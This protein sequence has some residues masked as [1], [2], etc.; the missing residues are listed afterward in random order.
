[1]TL[2]QQ[3]SLATGILVISL[4][5]GTLVLSIVSGRSYYQDQL[6]ASAYDAATALALS[7]TQAETAAERE[8]QI[9]V[10][11][12]RG[13]YSDI[14]FQSTSGTV[15]QRSSDQALEAPAPTWFMG[16]VAFD[17]IPASADVTDGWRR[18]GTLQ[19][20]SHPD[21]AYR[22]M[23]DAALG[24]AVWFGSVLLMAIVVL[25][26]LIDWL[27]R[28]I[29]RVEQQALGICERE[30]IVQHDIPNVRE[31]R[32]MVLAMNRMVE[33]VHAMFTEHADATD[34][35]QQESFHDPITGLLNR[36]GFDQKVAHILESEQ[37][38][39]G[40]LLILQLVEFGTYNH[41]HGRRKGDEFL[42]AVS[43]GL[44]EWRG[45]NLDIVLGRHSGADFSVYAPCTDSE[46]AEHVMSELYGHLG[47]RVLSPNSHQYFHIGGTY[48]VGETQELAA[49][50]SEAD[51]ALRQIQRNRISGFKLY[52]PSSSKEPPRTAQEWKQ[53]LEDCLEK[54]SLE[55]RFMPYRDAESKQVIQY[56]LHSRFKLGEEL[57]NA[58]RF[59]PMVEHHG[60]G[61][62]YDLYI[63]S[64]ALELLDSLPP[65]VSLAINISPSSL[66]SPLFQN[67]LVSLVDAGGSVC[68]R[69]SLE[70]PENSIARLE[71]EILQ[72]KTAVKGLGVKIGI[73]Q[74]GT[75]GVP[76][77]YMKR[78]MPDYVRVDGSIGRGVSSASDQK[79]YAQFLIQIGHQIDAQVF[80]DGIEQR[81]DEDVFKTMAI[82]AIGGYVYG[83]PL[84]R[85]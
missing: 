54:K 43:T 82:N 68:D 55:F 63:L 75:G 69:L 10:L 76:F 16:W 44:D 70:F 7:M 34:R 18:L 2:K 9:D 79:F 59:W 67:E 30:W 80:A 3:F 40:L 19:V 85:V 6:N 29:A 12:D 84:D 25:Y 60:L 27:F 49:A 51:F 1:M 31:L 50:F 48:V 26:A 62:D 42:A 39:S 4:F 45:T 77:S 5:I 64:A 21:F 78:V 41:K 61:Q 28:P 22:D 52:E 37:E 20:T 13:F 33:K 24:Q 81:E 8:R 38:H 83:Q 15:L 71:S 36:R 57:L 58:G 74:C 35:L 32:S 23:W 11:F 47:T 73:D 46:H 56:E 72:L 66:R 65:D 53:I 14:R 17:L